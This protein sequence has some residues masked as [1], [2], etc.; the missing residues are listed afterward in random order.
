MIPLCDLTHQPFDI[1]P[2]IHDVFVS[3][4]FVK[5]PYATQF[6]QAW[7]KRCGKRYGV[8]VS[9]GAHAL[10]LA[11][12]VLFPFHA[13]IT[14]TKH[15]YCAVPNAIRRL[16]HCAK[17]VFYEEHPQI[18]AHHLHD[19]HPSYV[20]ELEDCSHC[21]GYQPIAETAIFS[22]FPTKILG[23]C[24]DAGIIVTDNEKVYDACMH[25]RSHGE[26]EGTNARMDEVQAAILV[27]KLPYLD[28][29]IAQRKDIVNAYDA[30]LGRHTP[31]TF[32]YAYAIPGSPEKLQALLDA[33]IESRFYYTEQYM[34]LPLYPEL[35][36]QQIEEVCDV[37]R[38]HP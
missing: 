34:A 3:G 1:F 31:G 29:W 9:S 35:T 26:P 12:Q 36:L 25:L 10:E 2:V 13:T 38:A 8:A 5:G 17:G 28:M 7:A 4:R 6:E 27:R 18:Y 23:A 32:H 37:V 24:G 22:L 30:R 33:G 15:T 14:Y 21:H 11:I 19:E 20:P 16:G